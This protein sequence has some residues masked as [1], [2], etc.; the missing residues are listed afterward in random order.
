MP[1][2]SNCASPLSS[3]ARAELSD[4]APSPTAEEIEAWAVRE[5]QR[6]QQWLDG[7]S[8]EEK[9][10]W[11]R[12]Q[13]AGIFADLASLP[14]LLESELP[15]AAELFLREA[16]LAGKGA[17]YALT[18][19]PQRLWSYFVRAGQAVDEELYQPPRRRRV[20]Y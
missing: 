9:Q 20:R 18:R 5:R 15:E 12:Q 17:L 11:A 8:E 4:A 10:H 13:T 6:R 7:P 1:S 19:A 2:R 3:C 14:E 16:E